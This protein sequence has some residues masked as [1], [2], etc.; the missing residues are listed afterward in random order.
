MKFSYN[1]LKEYVGPKMPNPQK[2]AELLMFRVFEIEELKKT[3]QDWMFDIKVLP[4]RAHDCLSHVGIAREITAILGLKIKNSIKIKNYKFKTKNDDLISIKIEDIRDCPRYTAYTINGIRVGE[5]P[6]WMQ[7]R[8]KICGL[9]PINNVVDITNYVML[10]TGQ[11]LHAFD[12]DKIADKKIIVRRAKKGEL[13]RTLDKEKAVIGLDESILV[14]ADNEKPIAI[15]GIKGGLDT[16]IDKNTKNIVIEAANFN[17]VLI[18][19][20]SQKLKVR[21]DAS[22]RFENEI[23]PELA[24][25]GQARACQLIRQYC[26]GKT[27]GGM[28]DVRAKKTQEKTIKLNLGYVSDILGLRAG[29]QKSIRILSSLGFAAKKTSPG[30]LTVKAPFQRLDAATE[31]DL[32]EE[33]GRIIGYE[34]IKAEF[35]QVSSE[36]M[37]QNKQLIAAEKCRDILQQA[38]FCEAYNYSFI[39]EPE[40]EIF[41]CSDSQ[42]VELANPAS[43]LNKYGRPSLIP[44]LLKNVKNNSR[45]FEQIKMFEYGSVFNKQNQ[46]PIETKCLSGVWSSGR[47]ASEIFYGLKGVLEKLFDELN[48]VCRFAPMI[49]AANV[50]HANKAAQIQAGKQAVGVLGQINSRACF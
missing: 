7:E 21:T 23:T 37:P 29:E 24:D 3:E 27:A 14:I 12:A 11:P 9:Q 5:P 13:I 16:G 38:G 31:E 10:E 48:I 8:L 4:N 36:P 35:P 43:I 20:A 22:V 6:K 30:N 25:F 19:K 26:G 34:N 45:F 15:A 41:Y 28:I 32:I 18:R 39:G 2:L 44:H 40:K 1:W 17:P 42:L 47:P 49:K 46:K 33:I 50:F